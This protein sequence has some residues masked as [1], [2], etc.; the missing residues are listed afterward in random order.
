MSSLPYPLSLYCKKLTLV[1]GSRQSLQPLIASTTETWA[2]G[3]LGQ[4]SS[5]VT[6]R[7]QPLTKASLTR[8]FATLEVACCGRG[9][10]R[11]RHDLAA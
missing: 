8:S 4:E 6:Q 11:P 2:L 3:R 1:P 10:A 7:P 5:E 9:R